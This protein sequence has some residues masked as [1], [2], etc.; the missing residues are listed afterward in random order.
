MTVLKAKIGGTY[1]AILSGY[2][3]NVYIGP[4]PPS[5]PNI[6][7]WVDT[8]DVLPVVPWIT[9]ST[10]TGTWSAFGGTHQIP[11]YRK[12]Q[13]IVYVRGL[14]KN[15]AS[16]ADNSV[17]PIFVLPVGYRPPTDLL[18]PT[19]F[20]GNNFGAP[21]RLDVVAANGNLGVTTASGAVAAGPHV[22]TS[23]NVQFSVTS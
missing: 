13:D 15:S 2:M 7:F 17:Y 21:G 5:D 14:V 16:L 10:F 3:S 18:F 12:I 1:Q 23:I 6:E 22:F 8:D 20:G 11:Q 4:N 19:E 9:V